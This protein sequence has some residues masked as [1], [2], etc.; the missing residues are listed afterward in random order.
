M[1][2][3]EARCARTPRLGPKTLRAALIVARKTSCGACVYSEKH[4]NKRPLYQTRGFLAGCY[5]IHR[6]FSISQIYNAYH[7]CLFLN[8]ILRVFI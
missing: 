8:G 4:K 2:P 5:D 3:A 7:A 6:A 1:T